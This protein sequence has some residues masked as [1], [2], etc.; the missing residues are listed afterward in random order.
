M[1]LNCVWCGKELAGESSHFFIKLPFLLQIIR[2]CTDCV[3]D[4]EGEDI[5]IVKY[6]EKPTAPF[7]G[8]EALEV[9]KKEYVE[10]EE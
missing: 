7:V 9:W 10:K 6:M 3:K 8:E 5:I 2:F 4:K 1:F